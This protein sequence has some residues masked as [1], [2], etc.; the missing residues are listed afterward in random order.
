[1]T[2]T[3]AVGTK[4]WAGDAGAS[5]TVGPAQS[6]NEIKLVDVPAMKYTSEDLPNPRGEMCIRGVNRL[7]AYYK[8]EK[9]TKETIDAE[10]WLHT[11]DIAEIDSCGRFKIIDR[12]KNIM[13]LSQG[14]YVALEKIENTYTTCPIVAQIY[15]HGDSLQSFLVG[16]IIP[17][18][19]Q[20]AGIVSTLYDKKV[21][22]DNVEALSAACSDP[23]VTQY[24]L[25]MLTQEGKR[26]NLKGF[27][28]VKRIHVSLNAF[29][30]ED[31]TMTPTMKIRRK[32]AYN[33]FKTELDALYALGE[34]SSTKL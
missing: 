8:D 30:V 1:M 31:N 29:T 12:V 9:T 16:I 26:N 7:T 4:T 34:A 11:G 18:P 5:G 33:K 25:D 15:I 14:E 20:L 13:K 2:E 19:V 32:D 27:E 3:C 23:R 22:P 24:I 21:A 28:N 10:G 17:D 6:A